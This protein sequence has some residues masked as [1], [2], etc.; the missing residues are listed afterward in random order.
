MAGRRFRLIE[1]AKMKRMKKKKLKKKYD[2]YYKSL[3][4]ITRKGV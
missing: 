2:G 4:G 3:S 1:S